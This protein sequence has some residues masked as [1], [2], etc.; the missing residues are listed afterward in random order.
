M[1]SSDLSLE[2]FRKSVYQGTDPFNWAPP[3]GNIK[4]DRDFKFIMRGY[5]WKSYPQYLPD[6]W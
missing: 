6:G 5:T 4:N 1:C 3:G 2:A